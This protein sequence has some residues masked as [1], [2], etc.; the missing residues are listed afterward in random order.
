MQAADT[1]TQIQANSSKIS[2]LVMPSKSSI[3][4]H[5]SLGTGL[6]SSRYP[7]RWRG[8]QHTRQSL[9][10][11]MPACACARTQTLVT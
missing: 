9:V 3:I 1:P 5:L 11:D 7:R 2:S 8:W 6:G 4:H 10:P